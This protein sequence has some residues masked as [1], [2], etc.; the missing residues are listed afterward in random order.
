MVSKTFFSCSKSNLPVFPVQNYINCNS[1]NVPYTI[2]CTQCNCQYIGCTSNALKIRIRRHLSD[3]TNP[4][5]LNVSAASRHFISV[6][7]RDVSHFKFMGIEK[8]QNNGRGGDIKQ[9]LLMRE[10]FWILTLGTRAPD[11]LNIR[12]DLR[13]QV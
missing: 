13:Y 6:H 9:K 3:V 4:S 10:A 12:Q 8:V 2:I 7:N 1:K 11:G 5:S